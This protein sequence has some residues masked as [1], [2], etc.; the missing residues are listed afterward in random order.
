VL[1][2]TESQ[3]PNAR[4]HQRIDKLKGKTP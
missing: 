1:Q 3:T 2:A 4:V